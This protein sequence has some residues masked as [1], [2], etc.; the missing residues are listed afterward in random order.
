MSLITDTW[1]QL[2]QRRLLPVAVLLLAALVAVPL[3]LA[4]DPEPVAADCQ[5]LH[6]ARVLNGRVD[7]VLDAGP[8]LR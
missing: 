6:P 4:K 3:L 1:H 2:V 5:A 7:V 8:L